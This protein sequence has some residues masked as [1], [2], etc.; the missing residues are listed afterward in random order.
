VVAV[1]ALAPAADAARRALDAGCPGF[2]AKPFE[3]DD[4]RAVLTRYPDAT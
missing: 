1:S 2:L 4:L 3:V